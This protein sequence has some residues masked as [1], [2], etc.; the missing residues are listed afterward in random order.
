M[1]SESVEM[2]LMRLLPS[3][4][5]YCPVRQALD[6]AFLN[7]H[8]QLGGEDQVNIPYTLSILWTNYVEKTAWD[9]QFCEQSLATSRN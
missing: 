4:R 1:K 6:E 9:V 3:A 7:V 2:T 8:F 5:W